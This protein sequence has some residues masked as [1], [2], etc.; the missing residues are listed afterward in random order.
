MILFSSGGFKK[1][2]I[3]S[4][5]SELIQSGFI[6]NMAP[7]IRVYKFFHPTLGFLFFFWWNPQG[8]ACPSSVASSWFGRVRC[9]TTGGQWHWIESVVWS[10]SWMWNFHE[11]LPGLDGANGRQWG[12]TDGLRVW[13]S[14]PE[15]EQGGKMKLSTGE[16]QWFITEKGLIMMKIGFTA[17]QMEFTDVEKWALQPS[18]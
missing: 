1:R 13:N 7:T 8:L 9:D 14:H 18:N 10:E 5:L 4:S 3:I 2:R 16:C 12:L 15:T 11:N 6:F 17:P